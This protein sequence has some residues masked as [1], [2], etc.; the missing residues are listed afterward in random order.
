MSSHRWMKF[1]P[2]DWQSDPGLRSCSMAARGLWIEC[3]A[4]MHRAEP[5]GHLAVNGIAPAT[6]RLAGMVGATEREVE[7]LLIELEEAGV[8][9][10]DATGTIYSR[11]AAGAP[12]PIPSRPA[13]RR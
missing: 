11:R 9:S 3:I 8:F 4:I 1:W 12:S 6:K 5:Y 2:Q 13:Q 10:R 7:R